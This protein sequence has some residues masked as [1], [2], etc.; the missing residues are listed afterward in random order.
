MS[1]ITLRNISYVTPDGNRLLDNV[2][3]TFGRERT[4]IVGPNG[5][6]KSTLLKIASGEL[7]PASGSVERRDTIRVL[8]QIVQPEPSSS[9]A[10]AL[11]V[12]DALARLARLQSG[13][14]SPA[15]MAEADWSLE[16]RIE[17]ALRRF[18]L[19]GIAMDRPLETLSGGQHARLA[20]AALVIDEPDMILLDE[21]TNNLDRK[22]RELVSRLLESWRGGAVVISH[23]R[24]L[25]RRVDGI[26]ELSGHGARAYG[27][28]W[29][30]YIA[31][32]TEERAA[33]ERRLASAEQQA[34]L[35]RRKSQIARERQA[36]RDAQ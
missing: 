30:A 17:D 26:I 23:D 1:V 19:E 36:R 14:A 7:Q 11:G 20:L 33:A 21:P 16:T 31:R 12:R 34:K 15:D 22:G 13:S 18:D 9:V 29:E 3:L 2:D 6:G 24:E 25:L 8:E 35:I 27:G 4:A 10:D 32:K 28:N 5:I